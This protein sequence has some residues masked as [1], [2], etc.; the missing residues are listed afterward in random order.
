VTERAWTTPEGRTWTFRARP[1]ARKAET[2]THIVLLAESLG[3]T[4]IVSCPRGEWEGSAP[5]LAGLFRRS[6]PAGGSRGVRPPHDPSR[7]EPF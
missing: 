5:D 6:V 2:D 1:E 4:R 7:P 3:E